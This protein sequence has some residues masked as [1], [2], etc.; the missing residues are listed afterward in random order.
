MSEWFEIG[1]YVVA[2][3]TLWLC[4]LFLQVRE[5]REAGAVLLDGGTQPASYAYWIGAVISLVV[6]FLLTRSESSGSDLWFFSSF[7]V[8]AIWIFLA[9]GRFQIRENG[10]WRYG[11]LLKWGKIESWE[12]HGRLLKLRIRSRI[13]VARDVELPVPE[14]MGEEIDELLAKHARRPATIKL[15]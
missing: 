13:P 6:L 14:A 4:L 15:P 2:P 1:L 7:S 9:L 10:I 11:D 8:V 5:R 3:I 12:R